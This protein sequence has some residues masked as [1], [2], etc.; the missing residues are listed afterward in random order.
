[1][2]GACLG[3]GNAHAAWDQV[4]QT[5]MASEGAK[6]GVAVADLDGDGIDD[7]ISLS[8]Q[9]L[10]VGGC[11][12]N[13]VCAIKQSLVI[14]RF[15]FPRVMVRRATATP[16]V[17]V[18]SYYGIVEYG[19]W[20]LR[21]LRRIPIGNSYNSLI[22]DID[23]DGSD[24]LLVNGV[25][26]T[27]YDLDSMTVN[28]TIPSP[29]WNLTL[30]QLD[31][32]PAL[33]LVLSGD[34]TRAL[35][36]ATLLLEW[37]MP[38]VFSNHLTPGRFGPEQLPGFAGHRGAADVVAFLPPPHGIAWERPS[39]SG[40][41]AMTVFDVDGDGADE[42]LLA[43]F[44]TPELRVLDTRTGQTS[45]SAVLRDEAFSVAVGEFDGQPPAE[46]VV[47][48]DTWLQDVSLQVLGGTPLATRFEL[49]HK[50]GNL[51]RIARGDIDADGQEEFVVASGTQDGAVRVID[52]ASRQVEW[53]SPQVVSSGDLFA[54]QY[55]DVL[56]AQLDA[57]PALEIVLVAELGF[58]RG[59]VLVL[60]GVTH[61]V[62][63]QIDTGVLDAENPLDGELFDFD[64][65]GRQDLLLASSAAPGSFVHAVSL[66]DG[67]SL[68]RSPAMGFPIEPIKRVFALQSDAD[69]AKELVAIMPTGL[70]A[71]DATTGAL[72]WSYDLPVSAASVLASSSGVPHFL[73]AYGTTLT[74]L[75]ATTR[76][77][78]ATYNLGAEIN[79]IDVLPGQSRWVLLA[80][81]ARLHRFDLSTG[82]VDASTQALGSGVAEQGHVAVAANSY[83]W[84]V[85]SGSDIG[86]F[87]HRLGDADAVF[88]SG[89]E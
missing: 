45:A 53:T 33:E 84:S 28:W 11:A 73:I 37:S 26:L 61:E 1:M 18:A 86:H 81:N 2:F 44:H 12:S 39:V 31:G 22:G 8:S 41:N 89:F 55:V 76:T 43:G 85:A 65:D 42:L 62:E 56:L 48:V 29:D 50:W 59:R 13:G 58:L 10:F 68:W 79:A 57:D 34:Q 49:R 75:D 82:L 17:I 87:E 19:G 38:G 30:A 7:F 35:D 64:G 70:R 80:M 51:S 14:D 20:P 3:T 36:G 77:V 71:F 74:R 24:E 60:D 46:I 63:L 23:A 6:G 54:Q 52:R 47:G 4:G 5:I 27:A 16:S 78:V 69:A 88:V 15:Q 21:E 40:L 32:D 66:Q 9:T 67:R 25:N 83:G 72:D